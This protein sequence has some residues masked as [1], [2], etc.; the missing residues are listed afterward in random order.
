MAGRQG[1]ALRLLQHSVGLLHVVVEVARILNQL[2]DFDDAFIED[3]TRDL[4]GVVSHNCGNLRVNEVTDVLLAGGKVGDGQ[5]GGHVDLGQGNRGDGMFLDRSGLLLGLEHSLRR[6]LHHLLGHGHG[7]LSLAL[8]RGSGLL[9][10]HGLVNPLL[11]GT[12]LRSLVFALVAVLLLAVRA[13]RARL[14]SCI[15]SAA[16]HVQALVHGLSSKPFFDCEL[17]PLFTFGV[18]FILGNPELDFKRLVTQVNTLIELF[19][20]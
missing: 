19:D 8:S 7:W 3:H 10:L 11:L 1:L 13:G 18:E 15:A 12:L 17:G 9:L 5:N 20:C 14:A 16:R 2:V 6:H 4:T